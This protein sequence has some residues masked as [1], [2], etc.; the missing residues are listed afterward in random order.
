MKWIG[1]PLSEAAAF[2]FFESALRANL[3]RPSRDLF[4]SI[5]CKH[6]D[7]EVGLCT[8]QRIDWA[9]K[10]GELGLMVRPDNQRRGI[11][12]EILTRLVLSAFDGSGLEQVQASY[13]SENLAAK[14]LFAAC[15]FRAFEGIQPGVDSL[16]E[17]A[18]LTAQEWRARRS[19][20][21][22]TM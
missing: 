15:G 3:R 18:M 21:K 12:R 13:H 2:T 4:Y 7:A 19:C 11:G 9:S 5:R 20:P 22:G 16:V 14:R 1:P 17:K 10:C 6:T 8:L